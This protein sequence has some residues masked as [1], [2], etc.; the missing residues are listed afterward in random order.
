MEMDHAHVTGIYWHIL[1][2]LPAG[3]L[4]GWLHFRMLRIG[5]EALIHDTATGRALGLTALRFALTIAVL[6]LAALAGAPALIAA[7]CGLAVGRAIAM[8]AAR[9]MQ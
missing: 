8:R 3:I 9:R 4:I 7:G 2:A 1:W 5:T 6:V